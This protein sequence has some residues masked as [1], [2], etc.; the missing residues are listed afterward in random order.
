[1]LSELWSIKSSIVLIKS[2]CMISLRF[3]LWPVKLNMVIQLKKM[4][5]H[6]FKL[7]SKP[8]VI[9][10]HPALFNNN[11]LQIEF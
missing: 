4:Q 2:V 9:N 8:E 7:K 5:Q 10:F 11:E 1:M 3:L 6:F